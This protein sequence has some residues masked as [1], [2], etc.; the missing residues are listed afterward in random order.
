MLK[1]EPAF[2]MKNSLFVTSLHRS[3]L[4]AAKFPLLPPVGFI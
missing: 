1:T 3:P 4:I 2:G